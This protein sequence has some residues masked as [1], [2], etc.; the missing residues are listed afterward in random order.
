M[1]CCHWPVDST[2]SRP[3]RARPC[4]FSGLGCGAAARARTCCWRCGG[5]ARWRRSTWSRADAALAEVGLAAQAGQAAPELSGGQQQRLALARARVARP[6]LLLLD[7]PTANLDPHAKG[8][9]E[10]LL[11]ELIGKPDAPALVFASHNLGQ[12]KR[13]ATRVVYLESGRVMA[14]LPTQRLFGDPGLALSHPAAHGFLKG[15]LA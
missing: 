13:L 1:A 15:E 14:D 11:H 7:E 9:V 10:R 5:G 3:A 12:V 8:E 2:C 6:D 4:F